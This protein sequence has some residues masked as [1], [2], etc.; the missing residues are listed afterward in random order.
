[1]KADAPSLRRRLTI[2]AASIVGVS[3]TVLSLTVYMSIRQTVWHDLD[4]KLA[5]DAHAAALMVELYQDGRWE[6]E[7]GSLEAFEQ[8]GLASV[9]LWLDDGSLLARAP[10]SRSVLPRPIVA[11][12]PTLADVALADGR[13]GRLYQVWLQPRP[14]DGESLETARARKVG[15]TVARS[16]VELEATLATFGLLLWGPTVIVIA[17]AVLAAHLA[18]GST[19]FHV[20]RLSESI[21]ALDASSL[22]NRLLLRGLPVELR[23]PFVK[24]NELLAR[25]ERSF[26]RERQFTA[27]VSH[28]LRTPIAGLRNILEV[29][30][31]R[32]RPAAQHRVALAEALEV[33]RQMEMVVENLLMLARLGAGQASVHLEDVALRELVDSCFAPYAGAARR[34]GL[35]FENRV[36]PELLLSSD[37]DK[38]RL[39]ISNLVSNATDYTAEGGWITVESDP[40]SHL[41]V[42][43]RDS[44]PPV[45]EGALDT[46]FDPFF[47]LDD[48]RSGGGE[49][50]GIGLAL[51]RGLCDALG[52]RV[53]VANE[54]GGVVAFTVSI[55]AGQEPFRREVVD[56][57][58]IS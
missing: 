2:S 8:R 32:D 14:G 40:R 57:A 11:A 22:G 31:S 52:Y 3:L 5:H 9:E 26:A 53:A 30:A 4:A 54:A 10:F 19:L 12:E 18:I 17:L 35:R 42:A 1:M 51:V 58:A 6:I 48:S 34:R 23:P 41:V 24:L 39:V 37:R 43:V 28:E 55:A 50:C 46:I 13:P 45:P 16:T 27:D 29:A 47:R 44:G 36:P 15:I 20:N 25:V 33:V 38:L 56:C 7:E 21:A 49:H